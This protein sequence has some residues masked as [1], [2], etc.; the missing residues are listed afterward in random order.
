MRTGK[1][2]TEADYKQSPQGQKINLAKWDSQSDPYNEQVGMIRYNTEKDAVQIKTL[3]GWREI[4]TQD[5]IDPDQPDGSVRDA[6]VKK[7]QTA[8]KT[9][10][11]S[12]YFQG[13]DVSSASKLIDYTQ[14]PTDPNAPLPSWL[15][16][17][18][19]ETRDFVMYHSKLVD[20]GTN[21]YL[22]R[23][24]GRVD[25]AGFDIDVPAMLGIDQSERWMWKYSVLSGNGGYGVVA[26][27]NRELLMNVL[28]PIPMWQVAPDMTTGNDTDA[29]YGKFQTRVFFNYGGD[30]RFNF[31]TNFLCVA[32]KFKGY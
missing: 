12:L 3:Q 31:N 24:G 17:S 25:Q 8:K 5:M 32:K 16:R 26:G 27:Y 30:N 23:A 1:F 9:G 4:I 11:F 29:S 6:V 22:F 14:K 10:I 2:N 19:D 13:A 15:V 28:Q 21:V 18:T 7:I 20:E